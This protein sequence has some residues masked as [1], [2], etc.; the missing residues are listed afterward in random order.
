VIDRT[1]KSE[2][3]NVTLQWAP[4]EHQELPSGDAIALPADTPSIFTALREQLGLKLEPS[5]APVG[6]LVIDHAERPSEN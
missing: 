3:F 6:L 5:K 1:G 2:K 4:E